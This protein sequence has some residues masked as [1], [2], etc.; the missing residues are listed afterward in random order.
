[1]KQ[2]YNKTAT[3]I[4]VVINIDNATLAPPPLVL[5]HKSDS[6]AIQTLIKQLLNTLATPKTGAAR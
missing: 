4:N 5:T 1:M 3:V 2:R 6:D